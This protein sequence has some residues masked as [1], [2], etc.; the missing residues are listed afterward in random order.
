M[1]AMQLHLGIT[2]NGACVYFIFV[3]TFILV[4]R[5]TQTGPKLINFWLSRELADS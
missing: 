3:S 5:S 2:I 1:T 4:Y